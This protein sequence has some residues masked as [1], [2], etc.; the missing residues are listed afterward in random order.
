MGLFFS[1]IP[2]LSQGLGHLW[3]F[4]FRTK[5]QSVKLKRILAM[6]LCKTDSALWQM[7]QPASSSIQVW[8]HFSPPVFSCVKNE[9]TIPNTAVNSNFYSKNMAKKTFENIFKYRCHLI[10]FHL[11]FRKK[12]RHVALSLAHQRTENPKI[13][14]APSLPPAIWMVEYGLCG[15]IHQFS[16]LRKLLFV[17][18]LVMSRLSLSDVNTDIFWEILLMVQK[19]QGQPP[20]MFLK[21]CK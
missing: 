7:H 13:S 14:L 16:A 20:R 18:G 11:K 2:Q 17:C 6:D 9:G 12:K 5:G 3:N 1:R 10:I 8:P 19:S 21:P 15:C 4:S